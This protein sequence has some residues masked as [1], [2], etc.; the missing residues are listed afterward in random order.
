[1][2]LMGFAR[3]TWAGERTQSFDLSKGWNSIYLEVDPSERDPAKL[4]HGTP[5]DMISSYEGELFTKQFLSDSTADMG[6]LLGWGTWYA[7]ERPDHVLSDFGAIYGDRVYLIHTTAPTQLQISGATSFPRTRWKAD[8]Y[9]L[10]GFSV[11][12]QTPPTFAQFF[13]PSSAHQH[14]A[15]YRLE[16]GVWK[17]VTNPAATPMKSGEAFWIYCEGASTYQG[18]VEI[19]SEGGDAV[20]LNKRLGGGLKIWNRT[21][22][23]VEVRV[24]HQVDAGTTLPLRIVVELFGETTKQ[25]VA[26]EPDV[27]NWEIALATL[28]AGQGIK[29]PLAVDATGL[30]AEAVDSLLC[31]KTDLGTETW[32]PVRATREDLK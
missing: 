30:S 11:S 29:V 32:I 16:D 15:I 25:P 17:K 28:E 21:G 18:P 23:P 27:G 3:S 31:I 12:S 22:Y 13:D 5:V 7:P 8:A 24:A 1:M 20:W 4:V 26:V 2:A 6:T 10:V 9:N 19:T 14:Q